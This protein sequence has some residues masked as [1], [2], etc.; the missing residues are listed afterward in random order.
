MPRVGGWHWGA[1]TPPR[2]PHSA[3]SFAELLAPSTIPVPP[4]QRDLPQWSPSTA[5]HGPGDP[6]RRS[7]SSSPSTPVAPSD[8]SHHQDVSTGE[9]QPRGDSPQ[10][11][12]DVTEDFS[13]DAAP[14]EDDSPIP[15]WPPLPPA[16]LVAEDPGT[17]AQP[18]SDSGGALGD[19]SLERQRKA[20]TFVHPP[21][22]LPGSPSPTGVS[23]PHPQSRLSPTDPQGALEMGAEPTSE[24]LD[25]GTGLQDE[26]A[27]TPVAPDVPSASPTDSEVT[28]QLGSEWP[29]E[30]S[31]RV[32][33][34]PTAAPQHPNPSEPG[35]EGE[36]HPSHPP[37]P[38]QPPSPGEEDTSEEAKN[39]SPTSTATHPPASPDTHWP[40]PTAPHPWVPDGP[41]APSAGPLFEPTTPGGAG[42]AL[43]LDADSGSGEEPVLEEQEL[44]VWADSSNSSQHGE[45]G[46]QG[47]G[48]G[49]KA[50]VSKPWGSVGTFTGCDGF[51]QVS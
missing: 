6:T 5:P 44:L 1:A 14:K 19:G 49:F 33:D 45:H 39:E 48:V 43:L 13:G 22:G 40:S 30:G 31:G 16:P 20:V 24:H 28:P 17:A 9:A 32:G 41:E 4:S 8:A 12:A 11:P 15:P 35:L 26:A 29:L 2:E 21:M 42:G 50:E 37:D 34:G 23:S 38:Q 36:D 47:A 10:P 25:V 51:F 46:A 7:L 18:I 27:I 3:V